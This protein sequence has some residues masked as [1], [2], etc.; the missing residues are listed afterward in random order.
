ML[1]IA[2]IRVKEAQRGRGED[3]L[4]VSEAT[5]GFSL[6]QSTVVSH[7]EVLYRSSPVMVVGLLSLTDLVNPYC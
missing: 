2:Q 5:A 7:E 4:G 3:E 1:L 6:P